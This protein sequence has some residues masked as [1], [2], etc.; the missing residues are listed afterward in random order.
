MAYTNRSKVNKDLNECLHELDSRNDRT[1][2][3]A[4]KKISVLAKKGVYHHYAIQPLVNLLSD[5]YKFVRKHAAFALGDIAE[6]GAFDKNAVTPLKRL[7]SDKDHEVRWS[8][9]FALRALAKN[10][11]F[12]CN[13]I[14]C[15]EK[16]LFDRYH[17]VRYNAAF[18]LGALAEH[19]ICSKSTLYPLITL[20]A[21]RNS[22]VRRS[23]AFS[24][25]C[26]AKNGIFDSVAV[27]PLTGLLSDKN[28]VVR[29]NA[30][31]ALTVLNEKGVGE[32]NENNM[33]QHIHNY[34]DNIGTQVTGDNFIY[35]SNI[36]ANT[37]STPSYKHE[38]GRN[39]PNSNESE[40]KLNEAMIF[41]D[42]IEIAKNGYNIQ[43]IGLDL[44]D[45]KERL[46]LCKQEIIIRYGDLAKKYNS[47]NMPRLFVIL[48]KI[49][50]ETSKY[51]EPILLSALVV[52]INEFLPS[53]PF[54]KKWLDFDPEIITTEQLV[55]AWKNELI[56]IWHHYCK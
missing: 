54:F 8:A 15:F 49:N 33:V 10:N 23:A 46:K 35:K 25:G 53:N 16:L 56:K 24:I 52:N 32:I 17:R 36:G 21:D 34:G 48:D 27:K 55:T 4:A 39:V 40:T 3:N 28:Y 5:K 47:N 45:P 1:R 13:A 7:L 2:A 43:N 26:L 11:I 31:Q 9:T 14:Q 50:A 12:E 20:L 41:K 44:H 22:M 19:E 42:L 29:K 38:I 18:A 51:D 6:C 37:H 30:A